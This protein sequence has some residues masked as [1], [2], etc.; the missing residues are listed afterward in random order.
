M[1]IGINNSLLLLSKVHDGILVKVQFAHY[2]YRLTI[3][4]SIQS[5]L[6]IDHKLRLFYSI[7]HTVR[8]CV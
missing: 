7:L 6:A 5:N 4:L 2:N 3:V 1:H 8:L